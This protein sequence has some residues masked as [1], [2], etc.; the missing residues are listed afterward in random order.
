MADAALVDSQA[1]LALRALRL[2]VRAGRDDEM[3][4]LT[5]E[6]ARVRQELE[7]MRSDHDV[8][9]DALDNIRDHVEALYRSEDAA[10]LDEV[11]LWLLDVL[12]D[13]K[14]YLATR[15]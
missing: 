7:R 13:Y 2:A 9:V 11:P 10:D 15:R 8:A 14:R 5:R 1:L 6:L 4:A 12:L 3:A